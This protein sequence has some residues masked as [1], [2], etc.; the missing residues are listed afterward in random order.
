MSIS[1]TRAGRSG[2][3]CLLILLLVWTSEA[4]ACSCAWGGPFFTVVEQA[5]LVVR[6]RVLRHQPAPAPAL[7][8]LVMETWKGGL[9]DSGLRVAMGDGLHCRPPVE[10]F[11]TGSEWVFALNGPGSKPGEGWALSHCGE[12]ALRVEGEAVVGNLFGAEGEQGRMS[13]EAARQRLRYPPF[14]LELRRTLKGG[15]R[16]AHPLP[17]G[18]SLVLEPMP[19][20]WQVM[21]REAGRD[22]DLARLTPPLHFLP[23]PR[24]IEG[25]QF[26]DPLPPGCTP[27]Y[28]AESGPP[29]P[30]AFVFSPEVGRTIQG[31]EASTSISPEEVERAGRFG[32][33]RL[34][35]EEVALKEDGEG[36][37]AIARLRVRVEIQVGD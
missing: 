30:R 20:G 6:G 5:P 16:W 13:I 19:E 31:P 36:C 4:P 1:T 14:R 10:A 11:P 17:G 29:D 35:V 18:L 28:G 24:E 9:L 34:W 22:E 26:A 25:W 2:A 3:A 21:V 15:E 12:F 33:G 32:Q 27:P 7:D 37:P 23:N 8:L